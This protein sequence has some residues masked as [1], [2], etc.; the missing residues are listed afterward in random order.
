[1]E[2]ILGQIYLLII[3]NINICPYIGVG[4]AFISVIL[5]IFTAVLVKCFE[6]THDLPTN[7]VMIRGVMQVALFAVAVAHGDQVILPST[8]RLATKLKQLGC[9]DLMIY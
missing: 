1:M 2:R 7:L 5:T 4:F 9:L 3:I 6:A 8:S